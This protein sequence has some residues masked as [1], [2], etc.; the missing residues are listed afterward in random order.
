MKLGLQSRATIT[1]IEELG[2][3]VETPTPRAG[4]GADDSIRIDA[5]YPFLDR[6]RNEERSV[7]A[8]CE[9][10]DVGEGGLTGRSTVAA[11]SY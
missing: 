8:E 6:I 4:E 11:G 2:V 3:V 9:R 1:A 7:G 5:P 10:A